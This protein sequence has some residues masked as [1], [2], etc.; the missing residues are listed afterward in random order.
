M[1]GASDLEIAEQ[2][3]YVL[4]PEN[5]IKNGDKFARF[6]E[7]SLGIFSETIGRLMQAGDLVFKNTA[8]YG[9][10]YQ[11]AKR[12]GLKT[13]K[14]IKHFMDLHSDYSDAN[15]FE[16]A[17]TFVY[18]NDSKAYKAVSRMFSGGGSDF[19]SSLWATLVPYQKI[20]TNVFAEYFE[21]MT[22]LYGIASAGQKFYRSAKLRTELKKER[23]ANKKAIIREKMD[24]S[25]Q[26]AEQSLGRA[27]T[28]FA[29]YN[30]AF[31]LVKLG[32]LSAKSQNRKNWDNNWVRL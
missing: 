18:A 27:V 25:N 14:E 13:S 16:D 12:Q 24:R 8:Y 1:N 11:E 10:M 3:N 31:E 4:G 20:P 5:K 15:S 21:F 17:L 22:P 19:Y 26:R 7:G 2:F 32:V 30:I 29:L 9:A 28:G 23:N 6:A